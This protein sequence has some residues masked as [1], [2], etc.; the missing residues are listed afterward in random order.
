MA[1]SGAFATREQVSHAIDALLTE[2][3]PSDAISAVTAAGEPIDHLSETGM[4]RL[5]DILSGA[6][7]GALVGGVAG[8]AAVTLLLPEVGLVLVAG[9]LVT[10]GALAGGL[11]GALLRAGHSRVQAEALVEHL[12]SGRYLLIV[13]TEDTER[14]ETV[15]RNAGATDVHVGTTA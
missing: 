13:H 1:V 4:E 11:V 2:E 3:F 14:A 12:K 7:L 10:G 5:N 15:L 9:Q 8:L 6:G